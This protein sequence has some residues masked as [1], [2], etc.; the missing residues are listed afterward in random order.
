M[1]L[2]FR[3]TGLRRRAR[4]NLNV[5][6]EA[7]P[8]ARPCKLNLLES[9]PL[10]APSQEEIAALLDLAMRGDLRGIIER[11][12]NLEASD[13]Q[14]VPFT[15]HLRLLA[16]GFKEKQ[17]LEFVKKYQRR[18]LLGGQAPYLA[19]PTPMAP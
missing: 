14:L 13:R 16:K 7:A 19:V 15:S 1:N 4:S 3:W 5:P 10:F 11:A 12:G 18:Q 6:P 8:A 2:T 17:V 9:F